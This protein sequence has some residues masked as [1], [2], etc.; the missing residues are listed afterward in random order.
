MRSLIRVSAWERAS[1]GR[2]LLCAFGRV[3]ILFLVVIVLGYVI[4]AKRYQLAAKFWHWRHGYVARMGNYDVPVPEHWYLDQDP[5]TFTLMDTAPRPSGRDGKL[6]SIAI[7]SVHPF[8]GRP[9]GASGMEYWLS[10]ERRRVDREGV[11]S[12]LEKKLKLDDEDMIC[13]GGDELNAIMR[14]QKGFPGTNLVSLNC[15]SSQGVKIVFLGEPA[16]LPSFYTWVSQI[17]RHA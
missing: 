11:K 13:I 16:D 7:V 12:A 15:M 4:Y 8:R 14:D 6:H 2:R 10:L 9:T 3:T 1:L 17:R 5:T